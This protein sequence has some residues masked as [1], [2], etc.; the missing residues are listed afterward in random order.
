VRKA[1]Q[2][3]QARGTPELDR[4]LQTNWEEPAVQRAIRRINFKNEEDAIQALLDLARKL[5]KEKEEKK[6]QEVGQE[7]K[8]ESEPSIKER[9]IIG[10]E[11]PPLPEGFDP[12]LELVCWMH[13]I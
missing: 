13:I 6:T 12:N 1:F 9:E 7:T 11:L 5:G 2:L 3:V 8:T 10:R 4:F